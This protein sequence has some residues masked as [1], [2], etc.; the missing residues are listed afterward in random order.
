MSNDQSTTALSEET[1]QLRRF[2]NHVSY[3]GMGVDR[4]LD[5]HLKQLRQ[6]LKKQSSV[7]DLKYDVDSITNYLR[8]L[9]ES[10]EMSQHDSVSDS[11][12]ALSL[13][14]DEL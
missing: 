5:E 12:S 6:S 9:E 1:E 8:E 2:L 3:S 13:L 11:L 4:Q 7:D 10:V 14:V